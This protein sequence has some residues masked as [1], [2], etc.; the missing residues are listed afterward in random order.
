MVAHLNFPGLCTFTL[1]ELTACSGR[2]F[3]HHICKTLRLDNSTNNNNN[4]NNNY[5]NNTLI[6]P[7]N[8]PSTPYLSKV[9]EEE[10]IMGKADA[11]QELL[12]S[13]H[14]HIVLI[15]LLHK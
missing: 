5:N 8:H 1:I 15:G 2:T 9:Q 6:H 13:V 10:L 11:R 7:T 12:L 4:N 14:I 3:P